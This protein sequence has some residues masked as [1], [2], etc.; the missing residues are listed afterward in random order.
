MATIRTLSECHL[1]AV[2][3]LFARVY[4]EHRWSS[5]AACASYFREV[6]FR[7]PWRDFDLPS[8]VAE[9]DGR[10]VGCYAVLPRRMRFREQPIRVAVGCQFMV[11]PDRRHSLTALQL[12]KACLSGPQDLTLADGASYQIRRGWIGIG[13]SA[14]PLY[15]LHWTR[16]LRPVRHLLS[17]LEQRG[18]LPSTLTHAVRPM[19]A[20][21]DAL[22]ARLRPNRFH[23][24]PGDVTGVELDPATMLS[25]LPGFMRGYS[26]QP[27]YDDRSLPWLLEQAARKTKQGK[28]RARA[29]HDGGQGLI[30]WYLYYLQ[31]GGI[32]EV[33]QIVAR[34]DTFDRVLREL[35]TDAW[36][37]GAAAIRGRLD[38]CFAQELSD[39]HCWMRTD[40]TWTLVHSRHPEIIAAIH[41]GA[42][43]LSRLEG[44][45]WL[46]FLD[47]EAAPDSAH[48][49]LEGATRRTISKSFPGIWTRS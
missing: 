16:P 33:V 49:A 18:A 15:G 19:G 31:A 21:A 40:G 35:L 24:R 34:N 27:A 8:W 1:P 43:F 12:A 9:E 29:V 13:G 36:R 32:S 41:Q 42:A 23:L 39:Q 22:A 44:E 17:L 26:L 48:R 30:G 20:L 46:R 5:Q 6:L 14:S 11:D 37:H 2:A 4:P 3:A 45:W 7:N 38:P 47:G 28:L 10:I 25:H